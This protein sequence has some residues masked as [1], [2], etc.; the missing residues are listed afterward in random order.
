[1]VLLD[2]PTVGLDPEATREVRAVVAELRREGRTIVLCTHDLDEV[3]RLCSRAA[4]VATRLI[5]VHAIASAQAARLRIDLAGPC[6]AAA[7]A[8]RSVSAV[9]AVSEQ[10]PARLV[11]ELA[12]PAAAPDAI[13]ALVRAGARIAAAVPVRDPL[14]VAYL[15]LLAEARARGLLQ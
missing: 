15:V 6:A 14:E 11:L 8:A 4:F 9:R 12:D 5:G 2:E 1:V 3:E 13:E 7:G 10:D